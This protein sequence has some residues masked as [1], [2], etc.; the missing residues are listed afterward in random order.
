MLVELIMAFSPEHMVALLWL[1]PL[2]WMF[3]GA[4]GALFVVM[5]EVK[6]VVSPHSLVT[7]A[8]MVEVPLDVGDQ[9]TV[10]FLPEPEMVP[11]P[12]IDH[13]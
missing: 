12:L 8:V 5:T 6:S 1:L 7:C 4:E 2:I 13:E 3:P 11:P 9:L 10:A